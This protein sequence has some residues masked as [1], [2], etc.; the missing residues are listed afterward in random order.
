[1][2]KEGETEITTPLWVKTISGSALLPV[3]T[4]IIERSHSTASGRKEVEEEFRLPH[5]VELMDDE[6]DEVLS[7]VKRV[8]MDPSLAVAEL[9]DIP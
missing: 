6:A 3:P 2:I 7:P 8:K 9:G 4:F 1:L 5:V